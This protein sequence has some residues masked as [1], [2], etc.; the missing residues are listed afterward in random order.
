MKKQLFDDVI[1][2]WLQGV[3]FGA[4]MSHGNAEMFLP[5]QDDAGVN[6][7]ISVD[8]EG[9]EHTAT[10][11]AAQFNVVKDKLVIARKVEFESSFQRL[12]CELDNALQ[13]IRR[14]MSEHGA[15]KILERRGSQFSA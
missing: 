15:S 6:Y 11:T 13:T 9:Q 14:W 1:Q 12:D 3:K 8:G 4:L 7:Q 5:L 2:R 10:I